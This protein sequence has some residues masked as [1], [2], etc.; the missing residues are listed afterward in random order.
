MLAHLDWLT[1]PARAQ[2]PDALIEIAWDSRHDGQCNAAKLFGLD[3][4]D[5]AVSFAATKNAS[6]HNLY[7]SLTLKKPSTAREGRTSGDDFLVMT[8]L[9]VDA[10]ANAGAVEHALRAIGEPELIITTGTRPTLRQQ[11]WLR[12]DTVCTDPALAER[13]F[14]DL[15]ASVGGDKN[16]TGL[17]RLMRL[18]GSVSFPPMKKQM[19]GYVAELTTLSGD[20]AA[21]RISIEAVAAKL[22]PR[23]D[24]V[25]ARRSQPKPRGVTQS[26]LAG[27]ENAPAYTEAEVY[28]LRS[29]L[30]A[31]P[32]DDREIWLRC[33]MALHWLAGK[34]WPEGACRGL[35]DGWSQSSEKFDEADQEKAWRSFVRPYDGPPVTIATV[36]A[37]AKEQGWCDAPPPGFTSWGDFT[38]R[39]SDGLTLEVERKRGKN[40]EAEKIWIAA[41]FEVLG[42]CRDPHGR[43]WG[44]MLRFRDADKRVHTPHVSD[45]SLQGEPAALCAT[46]ADEGLAINRSRQKELALYLNG[47]NV[48]ARVTLV[49]R[50]GWHNVGGREV[51]VLPSASYGGDDK[52]AIVLDGA[53]AGP[54]ESARSLG[55]W[56]HGVGELAKG[57]KLPV[58]M[59]SAALAGPLAHIV[60]AEGGGLHTFGLSSIGKS[61]ILCAAASV[62]GRGATPGYVRSWR[63]TA[64]GL[65]GAAANATDT[66]LVLDELGVGEAREV[67]STIY[68]LANG[69]G[70]SR[71]ARDG[72]LREPKT[73]RV[74]VLS[75]GEVP[76]E[77]KLREDRGRKT[78]A[79]QAIRLLDVPAD[80]GLGFGTFDHAGGFDDAG[81]LADAMKTAAVTAYGTAGPEF[82]RR[83][84]GVGVDVVAAMARDYISAFT[85]QVLKPGG[86]EQVQRAAKKFALIAAAGELAMH[87]DIT[88]WSKGE[89]ANAAAWAFRRWTETRGGVGSH[90]ERQAI[91]QVRLVI[92]QYGESRFEPLDGPGTDAVRDRL[93][94]RKGSGPAREWYVPPETWKQMICEG[95][96][97]NFVARALAARRMLR[98]GEADH[99]QSKVTLSD[100][101]RIRAYV[102]T[103]TILDDGD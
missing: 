45:A 77:G 84:I 24:G 62:W 99:L 25:T 51:F 28:H 61:A 60:G 73:W 88:P 7:V 86:S 2:F 74:S 68:Q 40:F 4:I 67:A 100:G 38:M 17:N 70:K 18:G 14:T 83:L 37:M 27:F 94:W 63:A 78:R 103:A 71:A 98:R 29:A 39:E 82:I 9:A 52:E 35:W 19:R 66:C 69:S 97:A 11:H 80:R 15:V 81:K 44:R 3:E 32:S 21:G 56:K 36:F 90:E 87:L 85:R 26:I 42:R 49:A 1:A 47:A 13:V 95:L 79:G 64:N 53:A 54:Y 92:E 102:L 43:A 5:A 22:S 16:A 93:G 96:D 101:R 91:E 30:A 33:G 89:A 8:A 48:A 57:Q 65:E 76:V 75:S 34:G 23:L 20:K 59:V 31:V 6:G 12:L 72:S 55:D 10:D 46:L 41:P 50:T 58:L